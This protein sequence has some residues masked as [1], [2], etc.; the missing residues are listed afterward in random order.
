M[1]WDTPVVEILP[2]FAVADPDLTEDIT[3]RHLVCACTGVPRRDLEM[4][5]NTDELTAEGIVES[6]ATFEFFTDFGEAFQYSNQMVATGGYVAALA[7]GGEYG[8][9]GE[10]YVAQ[11]QERVL[12]PIG[13]DSSTFSFESVRVNPNQAV[14]HSRSRDGAFV[15]LPLDQERFVVPCAPAGALWSNVLDMSRYLITELNR[16][17]APDGTRVVS[18][19]NLAVTW[20]PQ[21]AITAD[22]DY[23]LGWIVQ[24]YKGLRL[25]HHGGNTVGFSS[26]LAFLPEAGLGIVVLTNQRVSLLPEAVRFRLFELLFQLESEYDEQAEFA[27]TMMGKVHAEIV[28]EFVGGG[29]AAEEVA[30]YLGQYSNDALGPIWIERESDGRVYLDVGEFRVELCALKSGGYSVCEGLFLGT[31]LEPDEDESGNP[32]IA[33]G[34]GVNEYVFVKQP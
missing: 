23:G 17:I 32:T 28:S 24:D 6:L 34:T 14:P 4:I 21:V 22:M 7:A 18:E 2:S 5:F 30:P 16:G 26:D 8:Q 15:P 31:P 13:M 20:E 29:I 1:S 11:M 9:L 27:R 10:A 3:V 33:L 25:L 19:E 12:D